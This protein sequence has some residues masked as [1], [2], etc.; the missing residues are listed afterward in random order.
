MTAEEDYVEFHEWLARTAAALS[1]RESRR[2]DRRILEGENVVS[3]RRANGQVCVHR[4]PSPFKH[5]ISRIRVWWARRRFKRNRFE[6]NENIMTDETKRNP[7]Q[8]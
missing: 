2:V 6:P 1:D 7:G 8:S 3:S 5:P 4:V